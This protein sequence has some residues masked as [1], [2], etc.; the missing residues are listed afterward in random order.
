MPELTIAVGENIGPE[1]I[2]WDT[3]EFVPAFTVDTIRMQLEWAAYQGTTVDSIL[4]QF[5]ICYGGLTRHAVEIYNYLRGLGIP[6][7]AHVLSI[8]ASSGTIVALAADEITLEHT[9][10]WMVHRPLYPNGTFAQRG[11]DL[12]ADADRL[13]REEQNLIDIYAAATSQDEAAIR[14]LISVDRVMSAQEALD[15]GFITAVKPLTG[16]AP[17]TAQAQARLRTVRQAVARADKRAVAQLR[18]QAAAS[19]KPRPK[20][21]ARSAAST[22]RPMATTTKKPGAKPAPQNRSGLTAAQKPIADA[23][24]AMAKAAGI[25]ATIEGAD[26]TEPEATVVETVLADGAG[27]LFTDG[28]PAEGSAVFNDDA[29]SVATDDGTYGT[30]DGRDIVVAGGVIDSITEAEASGE[31]Q[32]DTEALTAAISAA[33]APISARLDEMDKSVKAFSKAV[34]AAPRPKAAVDMGDGKPAPKAKG[35]LKGASTQK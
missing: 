29:L 34:P 18:T 24:R 21:A 12:R 9:A 19:T 32:T 16:K 11:E 8:T 1:Y 4:L 25:K 3:W 26:A 10:Q 13:D 31:P 14:A 7:R 23:I 22:P 2:D 5:G 28:E 20:N 15:F 17:S 30:D 33:L 27:S 35:L 6:I